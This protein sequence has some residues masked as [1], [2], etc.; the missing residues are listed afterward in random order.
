MAKVIRVNLTRKSISLEPVPDKYSMLGGRGLT[1]QIIFDEMDPTC[2]A[3][4]EAIS[5]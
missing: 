2:N 1:S 4:G 5:W 3:L